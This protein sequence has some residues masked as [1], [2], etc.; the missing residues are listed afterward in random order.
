MWN[1]IAITNI[2][3]SGPYIIYMSETGISQIDNMSIQNINSKALYMIKSNATLINDFE[4][5]N[6]T[7]GMHFEQSHID[8]LQNSMI[9]N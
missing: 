1:D 2:E 6:V 5:A 9:T 8:F 4:I 3:T 7:S